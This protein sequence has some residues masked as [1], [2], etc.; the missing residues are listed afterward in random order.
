MR[1]NSFIWLLIILFCS[2]KVRDYRNNIVDFLLVEKWRPRIKSQFVG[3]K[4]IEIW[5][6]NWSKMISERS[7]ISHVRH[8]F[9]GVI[10]FRITLSWV[11]DLWDTT[12]NI[13]LSFQINQ[14]RYVSFNVILIKIIIFHEVNQHKL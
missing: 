1:V 5:H 9:F 7:L 2:K 4:S 11:T 8:T 10:K 3:R 13:Y 6:W 14:H 12:G